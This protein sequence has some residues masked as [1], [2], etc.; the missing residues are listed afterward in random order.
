MSRIACKLF[1]FKVIDNI[2]ISIT[3][4][5]LYNQ[6]LL[7]MFYSCKK[8]VV[9]V[10][11]NINEASKRFND[12]RRYYENVYL[13]PEDEFLTKKSI[14]ISPDLLMMR[15]KFLNE[16]QSEGKKIVICHTNSFLKKLPSCGEFSSKK[17]S[18]KIGDIVN[19]KEIEEKLINIG[20]NRETVVSSNGEFSSRGYILDVFGIN[21]NAPFRIEFFDNQVDNIREFDENTQ[22]SIKNVNSI[23][24]LPFKDEYNN[25]MSSLC[26][27]LDNP[28]VVFE[29]YEQ[30]L[31]SQD[32]LFK[33]ISMYDN[34][35][36]QYFNLKDIIINTKV[37]VDL[38][39]NEGTYDYVFNGEEIPYFYDKE[40]EFYKSIRSN[41]CVKY[42]YTMSN[43]YNKLFKDKKV[44]ITIEEGLL[45]KG[46]I[47]KDIYYYCDNDLSAP[48]KNDYYVSKFKCG[49][50]VNSF[51]EIKNGDY[52]VH[53]RYGIGIYSGI[54]TISKR[55]QLR[56]YILIKYKG[57]DKL[58]LSVEDVSKLYKYSSKEGSKPK[59]YSLNSSEWSKTKKRIKE[60]ISLLTE[61]LLKIYKERSRVKVEAYEADN[62]LQ[63][64][65]EDDFEYEDTVDQKKTSNEIKRDL[66]KGIPMDRLLCG[67]VGY[68]KTEVIFRAIFKTILNDKQVMYL[69]PTTLLS[70]QQYLSAINRFKDYGVNIAVL[71]RYSTLAEAKK[72]LEDLKLKKIDLIFGTHRLLSD[73]VVFNDLGLLVIDEEHRFGVSHKEKIK[74][75]KS[76]VHVLSVSA[77]P[78]PRSLQMS[79]VGIRD[80]SLIE[81]APKNRFPV[82]TYVIGYDEMLIREVILKEKARGGQVFILYNKIDN[83]EQTANK[84]RDLIP[85]ASICYAN[86]RMHKAQVQDIMKEFTE[87]KYDCLISTT[88][89]ENG[90]DIPNANTLIV[91]DADYF[92]LSQ[93]YQIRGR[94]G[95][96]DRIA[97]AYLMY[98]KNKVLTSTAIKRL[99]S[100]KELTALGSGYNIAYRDLSIRGAGDILGRAQAGFIDSVGVD[101]YLELVNTGVDSIDADINLEKTID[102]VETHVRKETVSE[103]ELIIEIYKKIDEI[104]DEV[105]FNSVLSEIEDRYGNID[106]KLYIYMCQEYAEKL[107]NHLNINIMDNNDK[108]I[109]IKVPKEVYSL[110]SVD[111]L[112]VVGS[113]IN[114]NFKFIYKNEY[115][116]IRLSKLNYDKHYIIYLLELL[117][118]IVK[119]IK[120]V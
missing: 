117:K 119:A 2:K 29:D 99:E 65:F 46:F 77:T 106:D 67:D 30:I 108:F 43:K 17:I 102:D 3:K 35:N 32:N 31:F 55:G 20:Y 95:R 54:V 111:E 81:S 18:I 72:I 37:F 61:K 120:V 107:L 10:T 68:G 113:K 16:F 91:I 39:N 100:I 44:D 22:L 1:D 66:E 40:E 84:Y 33:M 112:F 45:I 92:G 26:E 98:R 23:D 21:E 49:K 8:N 87:G 6:M 13:F 41:K 79:L 73:D 101:L 58:Y 56:D 36:N 38:L 5:E 114:S 48:I 14:A 64:K 115:I 80:L 96:S 85:E 25:S 109:S 9:I 47:Y 52:V 86:G 71:N 7:Y 90:I 76:N 60:N 118:Y 105:S 15:M 74:E 4:N 88:I 42:F 11:S 82:Q 70:H 53:K 27:Y 50:K 83:M 34:S 110:L 93:L 62:D 116:I 59:I 103:D 28:N 97:Y 24:I 19:K 104:N 57:N 78:I 75:I 94:V 89:I 69:C 63:R 51:D 12:L